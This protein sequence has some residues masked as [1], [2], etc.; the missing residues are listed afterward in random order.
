MV[1]DVIDAVVRFSIHTM[2]IA[3]E[4][5]FLNTFVANGRRPFHPPGQAR[6]FSGANSYKAREYPGFIF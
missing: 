5:V 1:I 2:T 6:G 4:R 3:L